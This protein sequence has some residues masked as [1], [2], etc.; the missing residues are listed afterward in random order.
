M[1]PITALGLLSS[2]SQ[3]VQASN[4][5]LELIRSFKDAEKEVLELFNDVSIFD[6]ALKGFDRVLRSRQTRHNISG[7]VISSALEEAFATIQDLQVR[8]VQISKSEVSPMRRMK[9]VQHKSSLKKLH[10]R[11]KEQ[12]AMLQSFL[13]LA[14]A[15]V[16]PYFRLTADRL[17]QVFR[18][19]FLAVCSQHPEFLQI[20]STDDGENDSVSLQESIISESSTLPSGSSTSSL[21]RISIDTSASSVGSSTSSLQRLSIDTSPTSPLVQNFVDSVH[22]HREADQAV[23]VEGPPTDALTIRLACR[24]D[25]FCKCH[26]QSTPIPTSGFSKLKGLQHQCT[27]PSCQ[28]TRS[29]GKQVVTSST[30]FRKAISQVMSSKSIKVRYDLNT[31]RMVSEGSDAMRYVKHGNLEKLKTCIKTGEATL[32]D[33]APDGWSLLHVSSK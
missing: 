21:R 9:W 20:S 19:T 7:R 17:M 24:Y 6:E 10:G 25:C 31:Y 27:E 13:A 26:A 30:F 3:L 14:H 22:V 33:T 4:S 18:E 1:D 29:S 2:V 12:S 23:K 16:V 8:L 28:G 5:L 11:I 32:W 15:F